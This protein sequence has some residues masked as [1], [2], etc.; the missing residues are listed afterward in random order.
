MAEERTGSWWGLI[1]VL[2]H[3]RQEFEAFVSRPPVACPECGEPLSPPPNTAS[4]ATMELYCRFDAWEYP[5]DWR[6]PVRAGGG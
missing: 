1:S 3:A 4:G 2:E 5:R 6:P